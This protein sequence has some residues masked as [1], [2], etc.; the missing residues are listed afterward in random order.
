MYDC[1]RRA[2]SQTSSVFYRASQKLLAFTTSSAACGGSATP[3]LQ[4]D[5]GDRDASDLGAEVYEAGVGEATVVFDSGFG[6][7]W[8]PWQQVVDEVATEARVFAYSRPGDGRSEPS[9]APRE[10]IHLV[11][12][13]RALFEVRGYAPPYFLV[14]HSFGGTYMELFAKAYPEEVA[15]LVLVD[16]RHRDFTTACEDA[17]FSGR[18]IPASFW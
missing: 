13:L 2:C 5:G 16:P 9:D 11:E 7:D 14:G 1:L 8:T 18:S 3:T 6:N 12:A 17:G 4:D 15:G 10:A